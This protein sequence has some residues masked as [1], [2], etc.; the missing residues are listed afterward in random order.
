MRAI[1]GLI[2][3]DAGQAAA[4][5]S[6]REWDA[7]RDR[8][9]TWTPTPPRAGA[10]GARPLRRRPIHE[11]ME[12]RRG[13]QEKISSVPRSRNLR[14]YGRVAKPAR[15][16]THRSAR[17]RRISG[18]TLTWSCRAPAKP[19][20]TFVYTATCSSGFGSRAGDT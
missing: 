3:A 12:G 14:R 4:E 17:S 7:I 5:A 11:R 10:D 1:V 6:R 16:P 13:W 18:N 20:Y 8:I 15:A 2:D 19:P 9:P